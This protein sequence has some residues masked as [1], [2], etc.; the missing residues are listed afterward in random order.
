MILDDLTKS[1]YSLKERAKKPNGNGISG[2]EKSELQ[3]RTIK[4]KW[5]IDCY[6][7]IY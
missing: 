7:L 5:N 4:N 1:D 6:S 2:R 3:K